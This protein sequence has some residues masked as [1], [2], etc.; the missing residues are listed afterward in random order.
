MQSLHF[1]S[2]KGT[3]HCTKNYLHFYIVF[4][5]LLNYIRHSKVFSDK[6]NKIKQY[7]LM[8]VALWLGSCFEMMYFS[9]KLL[10]LCLCIFP[11]TI[12]SF[13]FFNLLLK[14]LFFFVTLLLWTTPEMCIKNNKTLIPIPATFNRFLFVHRWI[15]ANSLLHNQANIKQ[16]FNNFC[17]YGSTFFLLLLFIRI[18]TLCGILYFVC[19]P[20]YIVWGM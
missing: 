9:A 7:T 6:K 8:S 1:S 12:K 14:T 13:I 17:C 4:F 20:Q 10:V 5:F 15:S 16:D 3:T 2:Q 18:S 11:F 19:Y